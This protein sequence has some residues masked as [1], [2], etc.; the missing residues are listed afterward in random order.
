M[1]T[2]LR[3][4]KR[5]KIS[6]KAFDYYSRYI[7]PLSLPLL[8]DY[9]FFAVQFYTK[10]QVYALQIVNSDDGQNNTV[11][12]ETIQFDVSESSI[13]E[14]SDKISH[15]SNSRTLRAQSIASNKSL[16]G[17]QG[18]VNTINIATIMSD[19]NLA[20]NNH[21]DDE[22]VNDDPMDCL[23]D[24][25]VNGDDTTFK[26]LSEMECSTHTSSDFLYTLQN[27]VTSAFFQDDEVEGNEPPQGKN[28]NEYQ[29]HHDTKLDQHDKSQF[30]LHQIIDNSDN[31]EQINSEVIRFIN[32]RRIIVD[33]GLV[34]APGVTDREEFIKILE[35]VVAQLK[36]N[37]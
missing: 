30:P 8:L 4:V 24:L 1:K 16:V 14:N 31:K 17:D 9:I 37:I 36:S 32:N 7:P 12:E 15:K 23:E 20:D 13:V 26:T 6:A 5:K 35:T 21:D 18:D 28:Q 33:N 27:S 11:E 25:F 2:C 22:D 34:Y 19:K 29:E 3:F 10:R